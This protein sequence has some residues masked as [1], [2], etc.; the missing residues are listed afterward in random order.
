MQLNVI[1]NTTSH[2]L[3]IFPNAFP[4]F[5]TCDFYFIIEP[6]VNLLLW[7]GRTIEVNYSYVSDDL[8]S[9]FVSTELAIT[10]S[11]SFKQQQHKY[12]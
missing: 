12:G 3:N 10:F 5:L 9:I 6:T 2:V 1:C 8:C 7:N 11:H 4:L